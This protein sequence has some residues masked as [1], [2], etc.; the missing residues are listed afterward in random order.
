MKT[1]IEVKNNV[2]TAWN[3]CQPCQQIMSGKLYITWTPG[4]SSEFSQETTDNK[5]YIIG[6]KNT[7]THSGT[8]LAKNSKGHVNLNFFFEN[9]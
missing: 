1:N 5:V 7:V 9:E 6:K 2:T 4:M 3:M 8:T